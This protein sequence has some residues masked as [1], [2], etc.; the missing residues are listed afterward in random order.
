V[1]IS[2]EGAAPA[3]QVWERYTH[4]SQW[5]TW[6]PQIRRVD[7]P[8]QD[9]HEPIAPGTRGTVRG[10]VFTF[11]PF[12]VRYV[13]DRSRTW[14]WWVGFGVAGVGMDHGVDETETGSRAWVRIHAHRYVVA[15]YVPVAKLALRRL[16]RPQAG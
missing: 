9:P 13:D 16:V 10:P 12:R 14:S 11:A 2:A 6:A 15:P 3:S 1:L 8:D 7:V 4:P 5:P